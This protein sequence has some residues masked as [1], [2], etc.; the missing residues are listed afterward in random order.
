VI[1]IEFYPQTFMKKK[2]KKLV[3]TGES[4]GAGV[5]LMW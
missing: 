5:V 3:N 2:K 1:I 4:S